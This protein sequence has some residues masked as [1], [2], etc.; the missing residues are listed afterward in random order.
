[1]KLAK[2][3]HTFNQY[4]IKQQLAFMFYFLK[5]KFNLYENLIKYFNPFKK[6]K[7]NNLKQNIKNQKQNIYIITAFYKIKRK[8][9]YLLIYSRKHIPHRANI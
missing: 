9:K 3:Q 5:I 2:H 8:L 1:M 6:S 4:T 7:R